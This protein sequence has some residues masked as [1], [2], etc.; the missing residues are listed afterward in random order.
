MNQGIYKLVYSRVLHMMVPVSEAAKGHVNKG[1]RRIRKQAKQ[2]LQYT[3]MLSFTMIGNVWAETVL[4]A[5]VVIRDIVNNSA[6]LVNS[7][8]SSITF[9]NNANAAIVNFNQLNIQRG[10]S[11]NVEMARTQSF[12]ARIH[13]INPS[14]LNGAFNAA[15]N[16][17]FV[18]SNGIIIGKDATFNVGSLYAGTLNMTDELFQSGFVNDQTFTKAF[19]LVGTLDLDDAARAKVENAQVLVEGGAQITTANNGKVMLFAPNVTVEKEGVVTDITGVVQKDAKGNVIMRETLIRTPEGQT[20][21]AAGKKIYLKGSADPAGFMVEVDAGGTAVNLGKIVAERGNITMM[22]LAVNQGGTLSATTSVRANGS[23]RLVAQDRATE[24][25]VDVIGSRNGAVT[26]TKDSITEVTPDYADKEETIVSQPF[27]TSDVTIEASLINIDG[28]ISVKGGNVTAKSEFDA[29]SQLKFNS[30]GNVDL[31]L[32][33]DTALTGQNTRRIYLGENA[34]IDV[35]GVDAI[36]PMSRNELEVQL[37]SDQL[38]DAP[39][40]RDSGLFRQTVY[41]DAR[42]GTDLFDIQ[43]FLDLV[44]VTV[45]EKMTSAGTVTLSTNKDLIMNKGA[46]IDV[47]GGST[48]YTAGTVKESSLLF[49]GK[50]VAISDAKAGLA[51]DEVADSKE[52]VDEKWGTVRTFELGGTTQS[53]KT[54]FEGADAGTV[55]LATPIEADNTQNLVLAG[56]LIA[57]TKVSREQLLKQEAPA[58]GT[59][60][61]SA[62]NLVI[63]K[64]AKALPENFN[65]NQALPNSANYQSVISSNF[66]EGFNHIDLT[67]VTQLT[68]NTQLNVKPHGEVIFGNSGADTVTNINANIIAPNTNLILQSLRTNVADNVT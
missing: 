64:Q 36:A 28:K 14:S 45:A 13:D 51:Y 37:F 23:V 4:P 3:L 25:G 24:S 19:E 11:F 49:N 40:L 7:T 50:L 68:V 44:G 57:N 38:K 6:S 60:I 58:H 56:Q 32:D 54:Y 66:L 30:Q 33:P 16:L 39:I 53:V 20:I 59:L 48:T 5:G 22:G 67:K 2:A 63:D 35:S 42:K 1:G 12:M 15:G 62:N 8:A 27:K 61:A 18:N 52:L 17:Y 41:V 55:N 26:L 10:E 46:V 34:S 65:F 43:P 31:G 29:S 47:S 9:R 21:L